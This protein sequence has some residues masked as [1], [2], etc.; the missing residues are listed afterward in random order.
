MVEA[1]RP[2]GLYVSYTAHRR[3]ATTNRSASSKL[4]CTGS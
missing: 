1:S 4:F 2:D 3:S